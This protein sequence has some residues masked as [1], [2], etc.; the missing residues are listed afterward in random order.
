MT[1]PASRW[2]GRCFDKVLCLVHVNEVSIVLGCLNAIIILALQAELTPEQASCSTLESN[3]VVFSHQNGDKI[4]TS[5]GVTLTRS[6]D[7]L[8]KCLAFHAY[9]NLSTYSLIISQT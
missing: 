5:F 3:K 8:R 4:T 6:L 9:I 2:T 1:S 7:W